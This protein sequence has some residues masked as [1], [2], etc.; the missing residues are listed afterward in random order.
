MKNGD[1]DCYH[2]LHRRGLTHSLRHFSRY[3]LCAAENHACSRSGRG[4]SP[5]VT[6][7]LCN[8]LWEEG[9]YLLA[10]RIVWRLM[11]SEDTA[12]VEAAW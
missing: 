4:L 1:L 10:L 3:W 11:R 5:R 9:H 8:R 7:R 6:L 12:P 2:E